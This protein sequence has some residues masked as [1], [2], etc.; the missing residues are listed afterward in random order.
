MI[1]K[2]PLSILLILCLFFVS[3]SLLPSIFAYAAN[4]TDPKLMD[5]WGWLNIYADVCYSNGYR[6]DSSILV[7][8]I[9]TGID[10]THPDLQ[11]NIYTNPGE[12]CNGIDDGDPNLMIDDIHGWNFVDNNNDTSDHDGH[13][14]HCAGIIAAISNDIG[15]CGVAPEVQILPIKVIETRTGNLDV[16][17]NA[18]AYAILMGADIISMSIGADP[19]GIAPVLKAQINAQIAIAYALGIILVAAA[20]NDEANKVSYPASNPNV[21]AVAATTKSNGHAYYSN[22]GPEIEIAAPGGDQNGAITSTYNESNYAILGG[23]SMACPH[24]SG[25]VALMMQWNSSFTPDD[26]RAKIADTAID[27]GTLGT[28]QYFGAGL[29]NA[30]GCLDLPMKHTYNPIVDWFLSNIWWIGLIGIGVILL[31][32]YKATQKGSRAGPSISY[33]SSSPE[34]Y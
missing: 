17:D 6:G 18:I 12:I 31:I 3:S 5:Q 15:V 29:I 11:G 32:V 23:T 22:W 25:V 21:I 10:L 28:D 24:V 19:D 13:G 30:A 9:D 14:S 4:P 1:K 33:S 34:Y 2:K 26:I 7:A 20:G 27:L 16:L 8:V